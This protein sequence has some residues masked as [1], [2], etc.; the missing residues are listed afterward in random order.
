M[1]IRIDEQNARREERSRAA[2]ER[3]EQARKDREENTIYYKA[4]GGRSNK[5]DY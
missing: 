5:F 2:R 3:R 1:Q 4:T